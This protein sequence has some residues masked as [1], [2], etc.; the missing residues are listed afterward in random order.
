MQWRKFQFAECHDTATVPK[1][2]CACHQF[3]NTSATKATSPVQSTNV[4][5]PK[6][7]WAKH[8]PPMSRQT[9]ILN[10][11][12]PANVANRVSQWWPAA[13]VQWI[14]LAQWPFSSFSFMNGR[15][16]NDTFMWWQPQPSVHHNSSS[17][18]PPRLNGVARPEV[19]LQQFL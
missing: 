7:E 5:Q 18:W 15:R 8:T 2:L 13:S 10:Y 16:N 11:A 12:Q 1:A 17:S 3:R 9:F 4:G 6:T 14:W 19:V